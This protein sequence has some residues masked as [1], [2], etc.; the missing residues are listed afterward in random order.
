MENLPLVSVIVCTINC[1]EYLARCLKSIKNQTYKNIEIVL[2][3]NFSKDNTLDIARKFTK[4]IFQGGPERSSQYNLA[5]KKAKGKYLYRIDCDFYVEP[6]V[7]REAVEECESKGIDAIAVHNT[8]DPSVSFWSRVRKLE[9]DCYVDDDS[10]VA[11]RFFKSRAFRKVGGFDETM[12]AGE[13]YDLHNRLI[14][15]GFKWGRIK[16]KEIHLGEV[17]SIV[18]FAKKSYLYGKNSVHYVRKH[19]RKAWQQ[20]TP[21]RGAFLRHWHELLSHPILLIGLTF[22]TFVK[23]FFGGL[24]YLLSDEKNI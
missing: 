17:V 14:R 19:S 23:Y 16:A 20:M 13:D 21:V 22:M 9:R 10:I 12:F 1:E 5:A 7:V 3:D 11:V 6:S 4:N 15:A 18:D 2:V 8:S 24:G